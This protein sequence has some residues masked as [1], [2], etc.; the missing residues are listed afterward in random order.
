MEV[1]WRV[2][3]FKCLA[4]LRNVSIIH[5]L[6]SARPFQSKPVRLL[7][8][9]LLQTKAASLFNLYCAHHDVGAPFFT[10]ATTRSSLATSTNSCSR[11]GA[12]GK[13]EVISTVTR[14]RVYPSVLPGLDALPSC[15][16]D[17]PSSSCMGTA[18]V[19]R[20]WPVLFKYSSAH[21]H[22]ASNEASSPRSTFVAVDV[23]LLAPVLRDPRVSRTP[24][25]PPAV[26]HLP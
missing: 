2:W 23:L 5:P 15:N 3:V 22:S 13:R 11:F 12:A 9:V 20:G 14:A 19:V 21:G 17:V 10:A 6:H 25:K 26:R 18:G 4:V 7:R 16:D 8:A 1:R 24:A